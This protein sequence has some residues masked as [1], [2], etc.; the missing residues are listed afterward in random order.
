MT[1]TIVFPDSSSGTLISYSGVDDA[2]DLPAGRNLTVSTL[3]SGTAFVSTAGVLFGPDYYF[4]NTSVGVRYQW[5]LAY[6]KYAH[7]PP[8][9]SVI[10]GAHL[11]LNLSDGSGDGYGNE[12][13]LYALAYDWGATLDTSDW[14][15]PGQLAALE[16]L[17]YL[18]RTDIATGGGTDYRLGHSGLVAALGS[19]T[20]SVV[21]ATGGQ[22]LGLAD[23][24]GR[25]FGSIWGSSG[26]LVY[27]SVAESTLL[28][29]LGAQVQLS[30]HSWAA[31]EYDGVSTVKLRQITTAGAEVDVAII[32]TGVSGF[33]LRDSA[34]GLCLVVDSSDNLFV[35]GSNGYNLRAQAFTKAGG[36]WTAG[37]VRTASLP[38]ASSKVNQ[39]AA[40]W[41]SVG[42]GGTLVVVVAN[43][44]GNADTPYTDV[45]YALV[46]GDHL[47]TG[48]G[49]MLRASGSATG[50]GISGNLHPY[51]TNLPVGNGLDVAAASATRGY[52]TAPGN[53]ND[54]S[55]SDTGVGCWSAVTRFRYVLKSDG[56]G[57]A[58][59]LAA[60]GSGA[61]TVASVMDGAAKLRA[62]P[63]DATRQIVMGADPNDGLSADDLQN[64]G[65]GTTFVQLGHTPLDGEVDSMPSA[66]TLTYSSAWDTVYDA[67]SNRLRIYYL[68]AAD[69]LRLMR[70]SIDLSTHLPTREEYEI[71]ATVGAAGSTNLAIRCARGSHAGDKVLITVA[72]RSG[73]GA[74]STLYVLDEPNLAPTQPTLTQ[75][76][77]FDADAAAIFAWTFNDPNA[78]DYQSAYQ[79]V[80]GEAGGGTVHDSGKV[81]SA[82][83]SMTL[84]GDTIGNG[85]VYQW[86]VTCWD[87]LDVASPASDDGSFQTSDAGTVD[88]TTPAADNP[89]GL[90]VS[91]YAIAW[92]VTGAMQ[93]AYRVRVTRLDTSGSVLDTGWVASASVAMYLVTGLP[94]D[95]VCR[96]SV[97]A[98]DSLAIETNTATRLLTASFSDPEAP[99]VTVSEGVLASELDGPH[100]LVSVSNPSPTG[101]KPEAATNSI[102]RRVSG[103]GDAYAE[104]GAAIPDGTFEDHTAAGG[105]AYEYLATA[106]ALT[107]GTADSGPAVG[108]LS[109]MH[110]VWLHDP[111][112]PSGTSQQYAY[113]GSPTSTTL[114]VEQ[115]GTHYAGRAYPVVDYGDAEDATM[116]LKIAVP[117]GENWAGNLA[118]LRDLVTTRRSIVA[119][120]GRG[121]VTTGAPS[122]LTEADE[123]WGTTVGLTI[124]QTDTGGI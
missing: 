51:T 35:L 119:R 22:Y 26:A 48:V 3:T 122:S 113:R 11:G 97:T 92:T 10:T 54:T 99:T 117:F 17:G 74:L 29:V 109:A 89:D 116:A 59:T 20:V 16:S 104:V 110:G 32:N 52:I 41:H 118:H 87:R 75:K 36:S 46:N 6:L 64:I 95:V 15:T 31:L 1:T 107:G 88:I 21:L 100:L 28:H 124:T 30:D 90:I 115:I 55:G 25:F 102:Y 9:N 33:E 14:R 63:I 34:Q 72:N 83:E 66:A 79:L 67:A 77:A 91:S 120:D 38:S 105:V 61:T 85:A 69:G 62:I 114:G 13:G 73:G 27:T 18:S 44:Q 123:A 108:T 2:A 76:A 50:K 8:T 60:A 23:Y 94:S 103:S 56:S 49:N 70:T 47:L 81:T 7:T 111:Q 65:A 78:S 98:R 4:W 86:R 80:I 19:A 12:Y 96:I 84:P 93:A 57:F 112:D 40:A 42:T 37:A 82:T 71:D 121:R 53:K 5:D 45:A 106:Q 43:E 68:D 24:T 39:I 101:E 58:S